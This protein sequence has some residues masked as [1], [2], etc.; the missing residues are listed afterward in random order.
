[1]RGNDGNDTLTNNG[2][3]G[4]ANLIGDAGNDTVIAGTGSDS[5]FGDDGNDLL[6]GG[7]GDNF[8]T[9]GAG[10]DEL[11]GGLGNDT[12]SGG[13]GNDMF[14]ATVTVDGSDFFFGGNGSDTVNYQGRN[15]SARNT[16]LNL[17]LDG[18]AND[19][20]PGEGD[21]LGTDVEN[22]I[23]GTGRNL[24]SGDGQA[25]RLE[26]GPSADLILGADGISGNDV[27]IGH[28]FGNDICTSDPGDQV[29][30]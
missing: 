17:T 28:S 20:E 16:I 8:L 22:V 24:I 4:S 3:G 26:G 11:R 18:T 15:N 13:D 10:N 6:I 1:M 9:G 23:G 29:T 7:L 5:L 30:C 19:G 25:N 2:T 21:F 14:T 27:I 12:A